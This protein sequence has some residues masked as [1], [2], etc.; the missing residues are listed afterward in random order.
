MCG[1]IAPAS[2]SLVA[3]Q[4]CMHL[5]SSRSCWQVDLLVVMPCEASLVE[6]LSTSYRQ[7]DRSKVQPV[8]AVGLICYDPP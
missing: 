7:C 8:A 5:Q 4:S 3:S 6:A 1:A 2:V